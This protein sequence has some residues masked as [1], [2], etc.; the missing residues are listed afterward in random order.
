MLLLELRNDLKSALVPGGSYFASLRA[1]GRLSEA[2]GREER[3]KGVSQL[4]AP[5]ALCQAELQGLAAELE[6]LRAALVA[7][8]RFT[9]NLTCDG[10][11]ARRAEAV[12]QRF[13]ARLPAG[14]P[15]GAVGGPPPALADGQ[16]LE[17]LVTTHQCQFRRPGPA[18]R[19][20]RD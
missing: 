18:G 11:S 9:L 20:L 16:R 4:D 7:R 5:A 2:I 6:D 1:G 15:A 10:E 12:L 17:A 8:D 14:A 3:W 13:L 19:P